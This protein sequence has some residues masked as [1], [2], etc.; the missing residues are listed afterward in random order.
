[1]YILSF[2]VATQGAWDDSTVQGC[3]EC[4][5]SA[6]VPYAASISAGTELRHHHAGRVLVC[7]ICFLRSLYFGP[8]PISYE[9]WFP[10][11]SFHGFPFGGASN[12]LNEA[13]HV[14][15]AAAHLL[16]Y[17]M[18]CYFSAP[19]YSYI[20]RDPPQCRLSTIT[21]SGRLPQ[22]QHWRDGH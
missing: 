13:S 18:S 14:L 22:V 12:F 3:W 19:P 8:S 15:R 11:S 2:K 21:A 9:A 6:E 16:L 1:M 17:Q 20:Q 10:C 7:T 5:H 4:R